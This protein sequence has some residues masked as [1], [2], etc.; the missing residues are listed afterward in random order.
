MKERQLKPLRIVQLTDPHLGE[1]SDYVLAGVN[2]RQSLS[3][4]LAELQSADQQ[5][6]LLAV[7]GDIA[8]DAEPAAY[9]RFSQVM[10]DTAIPYA[11]L[12]G[13]HDNFDIMRDHLNDQPFRGLVE[14]AGWRLVFLNSAVSGQAGGMLNEQQLDFLTT[15]LAAEDERPL[16]IFLHHPPTSI[17]S[18]W[19]DRQRVSNGDEFAK[20]LAASDR[21]KAIFTG[22]VHQEYAC[23]WQGI[24]V[25]TTPST[26]VQFASNSAE[27]SISESGPGY[28]WIDLYADG[29]LE[30]GVNYLQV[31][32]QKV[33]PHCVG[34]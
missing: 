9:Q 24:N 32:L 4:V 17:D 23:T 11:W 18:E 29:H 33:D 27:F 30:T 14:Q 12:P 7:T 31:R 25:Y 13:N 8:A 20:V 22:H 16:A 2:T 34:Y 26:C 3:A 5:P 1:D 28:R 15:L 19:L 21:V 10:S 6:D